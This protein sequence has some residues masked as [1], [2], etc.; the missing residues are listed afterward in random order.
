MKEIDFFINDVDPLGQGVAKKDGEVFFIGKTLPEES[1]HATLIKSAKKVHF[2]VLDNPSKLSKISPLRIAAACSHYG[3]CGGCHYQHTDYENELKFKQ[4][5]LETLLRRAKFPEQT[6]LLH[7]A[8][9]RFGYRNRIQLHYDKKQNTLGMIDHKKG[10]ILKTP[11]C[12]LPNDEVKEKLQEIYA[13]ESWKKLAKQNSGHIE[14]Y[15]SPSGLKVTA[16]A[17]YAEGGFSQVNPI[18]NAE[19]LQ[20]IELFFKDSLAKKSTT[21][22]KI[23]DLFGGSGNLS[24]NLSPHKTYVVDVTPAPKSIPGH[25]Q[26]LNMN[27]Y[28]SD[29]VNKLL[30]N[31]SGPIS[32]L[33]IDPP[34]SGFR[35]L[36][37]VVDHYQ[38]KFIAYLSCQADTMMRDLAQLQ[39]YQI[40][41][42]HLFDFFPSTHHYETLITLQHR[43]I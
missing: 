10:Q 40:K 34:R 30:K 31:V 22:I 17:A 13:S 1:G 2:A 39:N 6:I 35:E 9:T 18:M 20:V 21:P 36:G 3:Q 26:F 27:L 12:L 43:N 25:Q 8:K 4:K 41:H 29:A 37:Q 32:H 14:I 38:P 33:I 23:L 42:V 11:E 16:D 7:P 19:C 24:V 5:S 28:A 15:Q